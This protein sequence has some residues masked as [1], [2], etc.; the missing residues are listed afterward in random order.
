V[1][2]AFARFYTESASS[3]YW[4]TTFYRKTASARKE[5]LWRPKAQMVADLLKDYSLEEKSTIVDIGGGYGLFA[6]EIRNI[7]NTQPIVIEP[8]PH[9]AAVCRNKNLIVVEKFL[10]NVTTR[11]LSADHSVF[12]SFELFEHLHDPARFLDNLRLLMSPNDLFI[13]TTLSST[14]VDIQ[15]LW[16]DSKSIMPPHHLNF[17]NPHSIEILLKYCGFEMVDVSTPGKL[18][19]DILTNNSDK[20]KDRFW[21]TVIARSTGEERQRWQDFISSSGWSSHMMIVCRKSKE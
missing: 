5:K 18:D 19:M 16:E 21:R 17:F 10:E 6:E 1:A 13:F 11:D 20:I 2:S 12:V 15:A 8:A 7:L 9:L 3:K 4:A 14:G